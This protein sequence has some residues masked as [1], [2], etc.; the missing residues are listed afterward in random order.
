MKPAEFQNLVKRAAKDALSL[1]E[2]RGIK[3][4]TLG[5]SLLDN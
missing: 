1:L 2:L 4:N 5:S 3:D